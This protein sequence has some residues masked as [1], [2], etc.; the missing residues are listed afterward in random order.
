MRI[1][2]CHNVS[3]IKF[4]KH[5]KIIVKLNSIKFNYFMIKI[6]HL[7]DLHLDS[8]KDNFKHTKLIEELLTDMEK[9]VDDNS[10]LIFSGDFLNKG[11]VNFTSGIN[12]FDSVKEKFLKPLT[13]KFPILI[14]KIFFVPGNHEIDRKDLDKFKD[15]PF[16]ENL[17]NSDGVSDEYVKSILSSD[18]WGEINGLNLYNNF[19]K[20]YYENIEEESKQI[21]QLSNSFILDVNKRKVG[22]S[23]LNSAWLC[24]D[25]N[26][27]NNILLGKDQIENS[28][29]FIKNTEIKIAIIHHSLD[30]LNE[31]EQSEIEKIIYGNYDLIF[32]G[33][34]HEL[35][36]DYVNGN[37]GRYFISVGKSL[38]AENSKEHIYK[39]GYSVVGYNPNEKIIAHFRKYDDYA[40]SFIENNDFDINNGILEI[41]L[42]N[43]NQTEL[44]FPVDKIEIDSNFK[45]FLDDMGAN[46]THRSKE[47]L[48][49]EDIY[50]TPFLEKFNVSENEEKVSTFLSEKI[51]EDISSEFTNRVVVLGEENSGKTALCKMFFIKLFSQGFIPIYLKG[52]DVKQTSKEEIQK[53]IKRE[54]SNQYCT[55]ITQLSNCEKKIILIIDD[56][57]ESPLKLKYKKNFI[58]NL[59]ELEYPNIVIWDEFFTLG[60]LLESKTIGVD[61]YE[62][63]KF[64]PKK[65]FELIQK[66]TELFNEEFEDEPSRVTYNYE[67]EKLINSIISK[68]LVP[69]FPI[70]ILTIL[71]A[72]ELTS[73]QNFEQSTFGHYYDVLIKSALGQNIKENKEIEKYYSYLSELSFWMFKKTEMKL[74]ENEFHEFHDYF[75]KQYNLN[76]SFV[77]VINTLI[78]SNIIIKLGNSYK[79]RYKY[80]Y[81]YF[82]GK[83]LSDNIE[84]VEVKQIISDLSKRLY[85]TDCANIYL[86]LSHHSRSKYVIEEIISNSKDL[87]EDEKLLNFNDDIKEINELVDDTSENLS[88]N[89]LI[90]YNEYKEDELN[91]LNENEIIEKNG[92]N[93]E[94]N[95]DDNPK[96]ID[97]IS[98]MNKAFKTI[99]I[100]GY[101][102]K[103][104][105]ASLKTKDKEEIVEELYTLGLRTLSSVFK[106][107]IEGEEYLKAELIELIKNQSNTNLTTQEK[108]SLAKQIM[109]NMLYMISYSIFKKISNSVST[110][111]LQLT[112]KDVC[113]KYKGNNAVSLI[114]M[115]IKMEYSK[116]FPYEETKQL[117]E[118]FKKN[119]LP[120][121]ILRRLG[122]N[123]MRMIP[124]KE[125]EQQQA[126]VVLEIPMNTQRLLE[127]TSVIKK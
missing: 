43:I 95:F 66:W 7:S 75:L 42:P 61:I 85:Q 76:T 93:L 12:P 112:F 19:S 81:F 119:K 6:I 22:I 51:L 52:K 65:R 36:S 38:T 79:I 11:G 16:K 97:Y 10:I 71:Q 47:S 62:I 99:E 31:R 100:L 32:I 3:L 45:G 30:F 127:N 67:L 25:N 123:F 74:D 72:S 59:Y 68:N 83:Y 94:Y 63:L 23:A 27:R 126:G 50:V 60:E 58:N 122:I 121:F 80:I 124:M 17:L 29:S 117:K 78:E 88:F 54:F 118:T 28:L 111:D 8:E 26:D 82:L 55:N 9:Y 2:L 46:F 125:T 101:I 106:T 53:I 40:Q 56:F 105:Y 13:D 84:E 104:R 37:R 49:L 14:D 18:K 77:D 90:S 108:E 96:S 98:Q 48:S 103:N 107:L 24:Y 120:F 102:V 20:D 35:K 114:D 4:L 109:F 57:N 39:N 5:G 115:A 21:T 89:P 92:E 41:D 110:K 69:S 33:H 15:I 44:D 73:K 34:T 64:S 87:F 91:D 1:F 116:V 70:Y 86:F 113:N